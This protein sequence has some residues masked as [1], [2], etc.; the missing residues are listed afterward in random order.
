MEIQLPD[1]FA[2]CGQQKAPP[3]SGYGGLKA[4]PCQTKSH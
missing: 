2:V 3:A 4:I 1:L